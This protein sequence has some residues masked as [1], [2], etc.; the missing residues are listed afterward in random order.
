MINS[1]QRAWI[2]GAGQGVLGLAGA[3]VSAS[4]S[5]IGQKRVGNERC[6]CLGFRA[7]KQAFVLVQKELILGLPPPQGG[8]F[9]GA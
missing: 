6:K 5:S 3:A 2:P 8:A 1:F 9:F 4:S 7:L